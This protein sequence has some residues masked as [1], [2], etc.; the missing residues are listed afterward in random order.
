MAEK[1]SSDLLDN[2]KYRDAVRWRADQIIDQILMLK[3]GEDA[4]LSLSDDSG[5]AFDMVRVSR[6]G[7]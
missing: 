2:L 7:G 1:L 4:V 3:P 6:A 5:Q